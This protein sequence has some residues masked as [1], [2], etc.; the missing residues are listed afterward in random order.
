M[1]VGLAER[2]MSRRGRISIPP[3][4]RK[5]LSGTDG[6]VVVTKGLPLNARLMLFPAVRG[7]EMT[8]RR[9]LRLTKDEQNG[10][11]LWRFLVMTSRYCQIDKRGGLTLPPELR[12][13]AGLSGPVKVAGKGGW[14]ELRRGKS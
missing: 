2:K 11:H 7:W 13:E 1:F 12:T 14:L 9:A 5:V 8:V 10:C 6:H 3:G 4:Y